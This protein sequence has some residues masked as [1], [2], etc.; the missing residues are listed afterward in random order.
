MARYKYEEIPFFFIM[1]AVGF[2]IVGI[3]NIAQ[4][5]DFGTGWWYFPF[6][7]CSFISI[8]TIYQRYQTRKAVLGT[9]RLHTRTTI[10]ELAEELE[11]KE[12]DVKRTVIDLRAEGKLVAAFDPKTGEVILGDE[13]KEYR[14]YEPETQKRFAEIQTERTA[15]FLQT[16]GKAASFCPYCGSPASSDAMYC[17]YCGHKLEQ[18]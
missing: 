2:L 1:V 18:M 9:L 13:A 8:V 3:L 14:E 15:D 6:I 17:S 10:G 16:E 4:L 11:M 7:F 5:T 12:K